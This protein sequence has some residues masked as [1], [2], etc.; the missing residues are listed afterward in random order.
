VVREIGRGGMGVVLEAHDEELRRRVA[1]KVMA[2]HLLKRP[3]AKARFVREARAAAAIDHENVVPIYHVGEDGGVPFI[4]MPLL[5]GESLE[6]RL[7][8]EGRLPPAEV[9]QLGREVAAGLAAAHARGLVHR[10]IKPAN[11]WLAG[12]N[13]SAKIL[14]FGLARAADGT[15]GLTDPAAIP[16]T[17]A[18]LA[19]EQV[20]GKPADARSDLFSLGATLYRAATGQVAFSGPTVAAVLR[21]VTAHDPPPPHQVIPTVPVPLSDLIMRLLAKD[22]S[23]RPLSAREVVNALAPLG[24]GITGGAGDRG[25]AVEGTSLAPTT[26]DTRAERTGSGPETVPQPGHGRRVLLIVAAAVAAALLAVIGGWLVAHPPWG[27]TV[28]GPA[29][30]GNPDATPVRYRGQVDVLVEREDA[31]GKVRLLRLNE[32]GALP[33]RKTD[34]FRVEGR[35]EPPAY[36]YVVWVDPGHDVTPIYPWDATKGWGSRPAKEEKVGR[37]S[38]PPNA[39]NRYTAPDA[40]AGVAT[41]VLF[42]RPTPL[43]VPDEEVRRWFEGLQDLP[44]PAGGEQA[45]VWFDD[46]VE[47]R[48]PDRPRTFGEVGSDDAFARWQGQLQQALGDRAAFQTA[49]SFAR[50]GGK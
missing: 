32:P 25:T 28:P 47:V 2:P 27:G 5:I 23:A 35:V 34:K 13:G 30:D 44:L 18:Y 14:D 22:P 38:L 11:I 46:Y 17:P 20:D 50:T 8:C 40:K 6:S 10:D 19:P 42:A 16:G 49:A 33:L 15:D 39:G 4:V 7:S 37:V 45:V 41:M 9:I 29:L 26:E 31:D 24:E 12:V 21:A 48:D 1:V 43:D 3:D 36:L